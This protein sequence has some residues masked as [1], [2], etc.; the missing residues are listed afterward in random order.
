MDRH[1]LILPVSILLGCIILG[2]FYYA[3]QIN[4]QRSIER[5]Q[6]IDLQA[7]ENTE[8]DRFNQEKELIQQAEINKL[9]A[10]YRQE[11]IVAEEKNRLALQTELDEC[12]SET[13]MKNI[14]NL[15]STYDLG[16][17]F[18]DACIK[19]K[20]NGTYGGTGLIEKAE[21]WVGETFLNGEKLADEWDNF[22]NFLSKQHCLDWGN[23]Q[24]AINKKDT[25]KCGKN[26]G[27]LD[28]AGGYSYFICDEEIDI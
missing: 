14:K 13:C 24:K 15:A 23:E 11:C 19:N 2:G 25:F 6:Q 27:V 7:K 28:T 10:K 18:I 4:K 3:S 20:L 16:N 12:T 21:R 8:Q 1:K 22:P 26:C 17:K 5:Q 9:T